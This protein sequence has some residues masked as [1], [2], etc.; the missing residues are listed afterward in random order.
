[1]KKRIFVLGTFAAALFLGSCSQDIE[2]AESGKLSA[3]A[4]RIITFKTWMDKQTKTAPMTLSNLTSF[5]LSAWEDGK[6]PAADGDMLLDA[7]IVSRS[8]VGGNVWSYSPLATWPGSNTVNFYAYS[9]AQSTNLTHGLLDASATVPTLAYSLPGHSTAAPAKSVL[10]QEDLLVAN[11]SGDFGSDGSSGV[12]LKFRHALSRVLVQ[13]HNV[14]PTKS[15]VI[16]DVTLKNIKGSGTLDLSTLPDNTGVFPYP[17]DQA[18]LASDGYQTFW[19]TSAGALGDVSADLPSSGILINYSTSAY[20][21]VLNGQNGLYIIPQEL[22]ANTDIPVSVENGTSAAYFYLSVTYSEVVNG[23]PLGTQH[24]YAFPV[25]AQVGDDRTISSIAFEIQRQYTFLLTFGADDQPIKIGGVSISD[26]DESGGIAAI[27]LPKDTTVLLWAGSNIY[28][29]NALSYL[30]FAAE[31]DDSKKEYQGV[32]FKWGSLT[33]IA[34]GNNNAAYVA[35]ATA[36]YPLGGA[37]VTTGSPAWEDIPYISG[38]T[39]EEGNLDSRY[40]S[41]KGYNPANGKG[42]ICK[43]LTQQGQAPDGYWRM[44]TANEFGT[45]ASYSKVD[46]GFA[47]GNGNEEGTTLITSGYHR[48][49]SLQPYFPAGGYR[50]QSYTASLNQGSTGYYYSS[51]TIAEGISIVLLLDAISITTTGFYPTDGK[52]V[53]CVKEKR[54]RLY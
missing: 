25:S 28:Y 20:Q 42:D 38:L 23:K 48:V 14:S 18:T 50:I 19:D 44:P 8:E 22:D 1:M 17:T 21:T 3:D 26:F 16:T 34:P 39:G 6:T 35:G 24:T 9:P 4:G 5:T 27:A 33:G 45:A 49:D 12:L 2:N 7:V 52:S 54:I 13:A 11:Q 41:E 53:R 36:T 10:Y 31:D 51:S 46:N 37:K 29:D 32:F 30:T 47:A 43:Y 15:Y 40:P